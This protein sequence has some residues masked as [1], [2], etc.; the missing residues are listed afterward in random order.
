[1]ISV[2]ISDLGLPKLAGDKLIVKI[3]GARP[4]AGWFLPTGYLTPLADDVSS[5]FDMRTVLK[6]YS[7]MTVYSFTEDVV[8]D[9]T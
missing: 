1:M 9:K 2:V 5:G 3:K 4:G 6:P 8:L 7:F